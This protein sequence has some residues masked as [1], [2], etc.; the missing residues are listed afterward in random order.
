MDDREQLPG[1][2]GAGCRPVRRGGEWG[3]DRRT[4]STQV[5][6][7]GFVDPRQ[8]LSHV[9]VENIGVATGIAFHDDG[10]G[11]GFMSLC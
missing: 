2:A 5:S 9:T 6:N 10:E 7:R 1:T 8:L 3:F 11:P 4:G